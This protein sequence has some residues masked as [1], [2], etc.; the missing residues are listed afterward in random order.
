[1]SV[2][3][4]YAQTP[5]IAFNG[6]LAEPF[7]L[8]QVDTG[9]VSSAAAISL[10]SPVVFDGDEYAT[11]GTQEQVKGIAIFNNSDVEQL[12]DSTFEYAAET[13]LPVLKKG[14]FY[15]IADGAIAKGATVA[16]VV[17]SGKWS[18]TIDANSTYGACV[19][20]EASAADGDLILLEFDA[21]ST[22]A[23]S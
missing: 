22:A 21:L 13:L 19:V 17:A 6:M 3:T 5:A 16:W 2:Q 12:T 11:A 14:R 8:R 1:M 9:T 20:V 7:S 15:G 23:A 10:G 4:S 18:T